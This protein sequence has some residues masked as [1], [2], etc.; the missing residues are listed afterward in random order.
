MLIL[1]ILLAILAFHREAAG[2]NGPRMTLWRRVAP[3]SRAQAA[4]C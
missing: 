3:A 2:G 4:G 1:L